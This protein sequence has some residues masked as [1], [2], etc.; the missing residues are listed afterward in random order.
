MT[1]DCDVEYLKEYD[2]SELYRPVTLVLGLNGKILTE[3]K[4]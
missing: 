3:K 2:I 1:K 4:T